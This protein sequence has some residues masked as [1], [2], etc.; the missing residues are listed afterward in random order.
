VGGRSYFHI[1][2]DYEQIQVECHSGYKSNEYPVAFTYQ[3][4]RWEVSEILDRWYEG[5]IKPNDPMIDYFK[6]RTNEG[7]VFL[8]RYLR[9]FDLWTVKV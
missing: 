7:R 1:D 5:G 9:L 8:L 2:M 3:G 4:Y 6:V